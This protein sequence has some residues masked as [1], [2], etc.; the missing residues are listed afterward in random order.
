MPDVEQDQP[1]AIGSAGRRW[2]QDLAAAVKDSAEAVQGGVRPSL[3][4][5]LGEGPLL[6]GRVNLT[7][8]GKANHAFQ[9]CSSLSGLPLPRLV[10]LPWPYNPTAASVS[11]LAN[12]DRPAA[13]APLSVPGLL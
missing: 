11:P 12:E 10:G 3:P 13:H 8:S 2:S 5:T 4:A 1:G 7:G 6:G 9:C